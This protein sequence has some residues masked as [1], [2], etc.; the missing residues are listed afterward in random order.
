[1]P[2]SGRVP[3]WHDE[4][5]RSSWRSQRHGAGEDAPGP[6]AQN[7]ERLLTNLKGSAMSR[8]AEPFNRDA[9]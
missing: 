1:M 2:W 5:P 9:G 4:V 6:Q 8:I 7:P 3:V